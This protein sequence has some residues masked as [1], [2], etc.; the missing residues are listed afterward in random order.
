MF[1]LIGGLSTKNHVPIFQPSTRTYFQGVIISKVGYQRGSGSRPH[2]EGEVPSTS[3][4]RG[5]SECPNGHGALNKGG[6][7]PRG[8]G[9]FP[10]GC[11]CGP[12][13]GP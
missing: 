10:R 1:P 11:G 2:C 6:G 9:G 4:P 8:G 7:P 3:P 5:R 12:F 13:G